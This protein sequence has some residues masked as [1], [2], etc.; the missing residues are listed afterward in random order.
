MA[1]VDEFKPI[2]S[3][4][5]ERAKR[6]L[7]AVSVLILGMFWFEKLPSKIPLVDI[8]LEDGGDFFKLFVFLAAVTSYMLINF[9]STA[10]S[11][12]RVWLDVIWEKQDK[13]ADAGLFGISFEQLENALRRNESDK[14]FT[15]FVVGSISTSI[16]LP[17]VLGL[18][19][20]GF[21]LVVIIF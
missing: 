21:C 7:L 4:R 13:P 6:N 16:V 3:D 15:V 10:G 12:F 14:F 17:F 9:V 2:L 5:A 20:L 18:L 8:P 11:D 19:A 1:Y